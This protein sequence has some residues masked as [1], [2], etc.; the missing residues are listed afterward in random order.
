MK[1]VVL[2]Y[3]EDDE[4]CV[5]RLLRAHRLPAFS[6]FAL[7]GV[8]PGEVGGW[9]GSATSHRSQMAFAIVDETVAKELLAA[10]ETCRDIEH[11]G[12]PIR[13]FQLN[14]ERA[15]ECSCVRVEEET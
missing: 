5:D 14:V 15:T 8:D 2:L 12:H 7:E 11:A 9:Y 13:A 4:G 6:R 3:L 1:M 10:V